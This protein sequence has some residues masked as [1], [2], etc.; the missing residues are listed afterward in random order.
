MKIINE[1]TKDEPQ[2]E[3][4]II[5]LECDTPY[6][7]PCKT[8]NGIGNVMQ[9]RITGGPH[10]T[11]LKRGDKWLDLDGKAGWYHGKLETEPCPECQLAEQVNYLRRKSG[12]TE[13]DLEFRLT[14]FKT[15]GIYKEKSAAKETIA[16]LAGQ[17]NSIAGFATMYGNY[18]VGKSMLAKCLV[19][20]LIYNG[21]SSRYIIA[22]DLVSDIRKNFDEQAN[23]MMMVEMAISKWQSIHVLVMD[24]FDKIKLTDWAKESIHRLINYRYE[25]RSDL[26]TMLITNVAPKELDPELGY[27]QSRMFAGVM[28]HVPGIDARQV[29][30]A[31]EREKLK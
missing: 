7:S 24:E 31:K 30:G 23:R 27:L 22:S 18:G 11:P 19:N 21:T 25:H 29:L 12:L 8:C 28:I 4:R 6:S 13:E 5:L 20:E 10:Q 17:G 16:K 14:D 9:F 26:F 1:K 15:A 3:D 2:H